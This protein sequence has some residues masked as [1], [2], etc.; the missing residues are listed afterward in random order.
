[1]TT[2]MIIL[3]SIGEGFLDAFR[4]TRA[5]WLAPIRAVARVFSD[6]VNRKGEFS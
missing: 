4:F 6:Y 2:T 3:K 5:L 1:M